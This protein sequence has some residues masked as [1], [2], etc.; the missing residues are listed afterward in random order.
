MDMNAYDLV[1]RLSEALERSICEEVCDHEFG[2][3]VC[4]YKRLVAEAKDYLETALPTEEM[5]REREGGN[6]VY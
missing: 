1:W 2:I 4:N 3:C 5:Y 6:E